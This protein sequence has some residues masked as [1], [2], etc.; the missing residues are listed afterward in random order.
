MC[1][2][3]GQILTYESSHERPYMARTT[4]VVLLSLTS[5]CISS[6]SFILFLEQFY[7]LKLLFVSNLIPLYFCAFYRAIQVLSLPPLDRNPAVDLIYPQISSP[8]PS[9][10]LAASYCLQEV[11]EWQRVKDLNAKISPNWTVGVD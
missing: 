3:H 5:Q 8:L 10:F 7:V 2:T 9:F 4:A 6:H 1:S 11:R